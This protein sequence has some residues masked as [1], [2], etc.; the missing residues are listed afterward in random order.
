[1]DIF[2]QRL[3]DTP[4]YY[5][6]QISAT[7]FE[8]E[9]ADQDHPSEK[10]ERLDT[11]HKLSYVAHMGPVDIIPYGSFRETI[12]S[13]LKSETRAVGRAVIGGGVDLFTRFHRVFDITTNAVG[14]DINGLRHIFAPS[15]KYFYTAK[16]TV[17]DNDLFQM[18]DIDAID[19]TQGVT[20]SIEN[21]LRTKRHAGDQME[22]IDVVRL[23]SSV[24]YLFHLRKNGH[25]FD[26]KFRNL[27]FDLEDNL[28]HG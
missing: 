27:K 3:W 22:T 19:D 16:P 21:K 28:T 13:R 7:A 11:F 10:A 26:D 1:M 17:G 20:F 24:D 2:N 18:D 4:F 23:I 25:G 14:L 5:T 15:V 9:Y 12:Y 8:K 6:S